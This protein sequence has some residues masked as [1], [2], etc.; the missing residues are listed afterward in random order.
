M[1][2]LAAQ[3][4]MAEW[5]IMVALFV[6]TRHFRQV[7]A[8]SATLYPNNSTRLSNFILPATAKPTTTSLIYNQAQ[9][10]TPIPIGYFKY[11]RRY[12]LIP[13]YRAL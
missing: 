4:V 8:E 9:I 6:L 5:V 13:I 2:D 3:T 10:L 11:T 12:Y 7:T 1:L